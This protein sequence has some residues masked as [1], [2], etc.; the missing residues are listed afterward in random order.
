MIVV[1]RR[2]RLDHI[3]Q[4]LED[5]GR[6]VGEAR[7]GMVLRRRLEARLETVTQAL[8]HKLSRGGKRPRVLGLESV[9]PLVASGL[10]LPDQRERMC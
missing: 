10:W 2:R 1:I 8:A 4:A 5:I 7:P 6:T 9:F 3:S